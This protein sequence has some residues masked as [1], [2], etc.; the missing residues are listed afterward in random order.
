[1]LI[2]FKATCLLSKSTLI[3]RVIK[4]GLID[5]SKSI[6]TTINDLRPE[7]L[8]TLIHRGSLIELLEVFFAL[9]KPLILPI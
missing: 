1:M 9:G 6:R 2:I 4:S 3:F 8:A 7:K 5:L